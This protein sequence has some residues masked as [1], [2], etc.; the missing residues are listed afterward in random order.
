MLDI[1][2][3]KALSVKMPYRAD[4]S[5]RTRG[6]ATF[7]SESSTAATCS[8]IGICGALDFFRRFDFFDLT[9]EETRFD[10]LLVD[11]TALLRFAVLRVLVSDVAADDADLLADVFGRA[12]F[13]FLS[14]APKP[15][16]SSVLSLSAILFLSLNPKP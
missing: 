2:T 8:S 14:V 3:P 5:F 11:F 13:A 1:D 4:I 7:W 10:F 6:S 9:R 15:I 12:A 16:R